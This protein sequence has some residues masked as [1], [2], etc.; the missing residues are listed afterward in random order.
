M[1]ELNKAEG[2]KVKVTKIKDDDT[3]K[4]EGGHA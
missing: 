3:E 1:N 2:K 4:Q